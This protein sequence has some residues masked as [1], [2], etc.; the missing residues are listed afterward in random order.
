MASQQ[1]QAA[2]SDSDDEQSSSSDNE[3]RPSGVRPRARSA[4][5]AG[6]RAQP[7]KRDD[8]S[9]DDAT[10]GDAQHHSRHYMFALALKPATH[11]AYMDAV[12]GFS[13]W[14]RHE[15]VDC[16]HPRELDTLLVDY[17]HHLYETGGSKQRAKNVVYGILTLHP[18]WQRYVVC[19]RKCIAA[20]E[21]LRPAQRHPPLTRALA[22]AIA[23][24]MALRGWQNDAIG[25]LLS[26][27]CLLRINELLGV[28]N[29]DVSDTT[30]V[31]ASG[32]STRSVVLR[33]AY[34]KTLKNLSVSVRDLAIISLLADL[35]ARTAPSDRLFTSSPVVYRTRFHAACSDLQL[36][37]SYVPHSLRH[38][39]A[40]ELYE[41][42]WTVAN[43][44]VRGRWASEASA[45]RYIHTSVGSAIAM[46]SA[47]SG[48]ASE[49]GTLALLD[50]YATFCHAFAVAQVR[51]G[52]GCPQ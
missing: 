35:R 31:S 15:G 6:P 27:E 39:G 18:Q 21:K 19:A 10:G 44:M 46:Q 25:V 17:M 47:S 36:S 34:T 48:V 20:F 8:L 29:S 45:R 42:G 9:T 38:G 40:T 3:W 4:R 28:R 11:R 33:L 5:R 26:F 32:V 7:H 51:G 30:I 41:Q 24:K 16:T 43:I 50:L 49:L 37:S 2:A 52:R 14:C 12:V 1:Q 23:L 13:E 22:A